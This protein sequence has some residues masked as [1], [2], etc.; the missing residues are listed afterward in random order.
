MNSPRYSASL[1]G[2]NQTVLAFNGDADGLI[3]GHLLYLAGVVPQRRITGLKRDIRLLRHLT[4]LHQDSRAS[5]NPL[6]LYVC[7]INLA[8]NRGDLVTLLKN[9]TTTVTWYDHHEPGDIPASPQLKTRIATGRGA[10]TGLLVYADLLAQGKPADP[11]WAAIAAFGDNLPE[12]ALALLAPL[13][14]SPDDLA[15]LREAGEL[16]NYNAYGET[17]EDVLY[18][19]LAVAER[20]AEFIDPLAFIRESGLIE[21]LRQQLREDERMMGAVLPTSGCE[22]AAVY[23]LPGTGWARRVGSTFANR[24]VLADPARAVAVL[25]PLDDGH[26]QASIRAPRGRPDAPTA[27]SLAS[28]YHSGGGR[29]LAAGIN[30]LQA[31]QVEAFTRRFLDMYGV[32]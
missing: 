5:S 13:A 17:P 30:R 4:A 12:A 2:E 21:P 25:H 9:P 28:E 18:Q 1:S 14:L 27:A 11:R 6:D 26:F 23:T 32:N 3:A 24:A 8:D 15:A 10:C 19:P 7:D 16:L 29:A 20:M 31:D 22:G